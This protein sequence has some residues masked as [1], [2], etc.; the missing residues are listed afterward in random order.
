MT[1]KTFPKNRFFGSFLE[2]VSPRRPQDVPGP[3]RGRNYLKFI[4]FCQKP[5]FTRVKPM[6]FTFLNFLNTFSPHV[7]RRGSW[8]RT[9]KHCFSSSV[10]FVRKDVEFANDHGFTMVKPMFQ[11]GQTYVF[12]KSI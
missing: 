7:N 9:K 8:G 5:C 6:F 4:D 11:Q 1:P 10:V 3:S 12:G 2:S